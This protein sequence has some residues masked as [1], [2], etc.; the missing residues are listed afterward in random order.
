MPRILVLCT[1]NSARSQMAEGWIRHHAAGHRV[2]CDVWS[3]G[4]ERTALKP[5]AI[6]V[7]RE[8]GVDLA[9]HTSKSIDEVPDPWSFD[10]VI[11]VCDA[12]NDACPAYPAPTERLHVSFPDP[13]DQPIERWRVVRDAIG[14]MSEELVATL[15]DG[16]ALRHDALRA[17]ANLE[18]DAHGDR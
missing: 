8:V 14:A 1:H 4:S 9:G 10:L 5:E 12:A 17:R 13:S 15:A 16:G 6:A 18:E 2:D 3:A 7:M 11:T